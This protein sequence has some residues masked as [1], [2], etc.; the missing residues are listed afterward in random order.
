MTL[1]LNGLG[2]LKSPAA[3]FS[4]KPKLKP[5]MGSTGIKPGED[6]TITEPPSLVPR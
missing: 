4:S 3:D 6:A 5:S 1:P 2:E